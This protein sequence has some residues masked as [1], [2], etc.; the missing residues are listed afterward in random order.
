MADSV[1]ALVVVLA[2]GT[3]DEE[4]A[5]IRTAIL[6]LRGVIGV[7]VQREDMADYILRFQAKAELRKMLWDV[8]T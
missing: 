8:L 2:E 7:A 4:A 5:Q 1:N 3:R 6:Q